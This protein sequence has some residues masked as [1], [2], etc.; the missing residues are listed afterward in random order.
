MIEYIL[1]ALVITFFSMVIS[2][3][4]F[5]FRDY[6]MN[7]VPIANTLA[8]G[9]ESKYL[10][11]LMFV[12][13]LNLLFGLVCLYDAARS[14]KTQSEMKSLTMVA[15]IDDQ[16]YVC[17]RDKLCNSIDRAGQYVYIS[18]ANKQGLSWQLANCRHL[19]KI[20]DLSYVTDEE[21]IEMK[22]K[23]TVI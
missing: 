10:P 4:A 20:E 3:S 23:G 18:L 2:F 13:G 9:I 15:T 12:P 14:I 22:L 7:M 21:L 19:V 17:D 6:R 1:M 11:A 16:S 8:P 5:V